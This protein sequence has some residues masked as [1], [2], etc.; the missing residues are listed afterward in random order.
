MASLKRFRL[1]VKFKW[2]PQICVAAYKRTGTS[3]TSGTGTGT[4]TSVVGTG[5]STVKTDKADLPGSTGTGTG[6]Y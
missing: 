3:G 6:L 4:G 1:N 2:H 5:N